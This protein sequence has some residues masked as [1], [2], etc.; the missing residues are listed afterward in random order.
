MT[1]RDAYSA[2][3]ARLRGSPPPPAL[4]PSLLAAIG[5]ATPAPPPAV[6]A[7]SLGRARGSPAS[8]RATPGEIARAAP[9]RRAYALSAALVAILALV[10]AAMVWN[11]AQSLT[12]P[13]SDT[14]VRGGGHAN[15]SAAEDGKQDAA[16]ARQLLRNGFMHGLAAAAAGA[17]SAGDAGDATTPPAS[18]PT[19]A[20]QPA[21]RRRVQWALTDA[22]PSASST[23]TP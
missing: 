5:T 16:A 6:L 14:E 2:S 12:H 22:A 7:S 1:T 15:P 21:A 18:P 3:L 17:P 11:I 10:M 9:P 13:A 8:R 20:P 23:A 19:T 4:P